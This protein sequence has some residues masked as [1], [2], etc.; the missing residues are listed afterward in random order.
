MRVGGSIEGSLDIS[1]P[2]TKPEQL[3]AT[4]EVPKLEVRP[5]PGAMNANPPVDLTV[6]N[7][8][9]IRVS[10]ANN[11]VTVESAKIVA[12]DS[13][14]SL[15]GT[16][17]IAPQPDLNLHVDGNINLVLAHLFNNDIVSSGVVVANAG[18]RGNFANPSLNGSL[19]LKN[20][21]FTMVNMPNG[22]S[23]ANGTITFTETQARI[24]NLTAE[25]G[26]G[27]VTMGGFA[28]FVGGNLSFRLRANADRV[29]VRSPQGI[30]TVADAQLALVGT[31]DRSIL[32]G[33]VTIDRI[34]FNP[35]T[36]LGS[37]LSGALI[38][39]GD[40]VRTNGHGEQPSVRRP[41]PDF[42]GHHVPEQ[43][44]GQHRGRCP[45]AAARIVL[46]TRCC[47]AG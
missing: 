19:Q 9:P 33:T 15:S 42:S 6:R 36:D 26:G 3:R 45:A 7:S 20:A 12:Q 8:G 35:R 47:W 18:V 1:G 5:L 27:K 21:N 41:D 39:P 31:T 11:V 17:T 40:T 32:S 2:A 10:L 37:V 44:Y 22:V 28:S 13:V 4:L 30:S 29:R 14:F 46:Q 25:S 16:A 24:Q 43:L 38:S 34:A 23:N